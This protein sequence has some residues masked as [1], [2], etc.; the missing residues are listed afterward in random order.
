MRRLKGCEGRGQG[1]VGRVPT[2]ASASVPDAAALPPQLSP[3]P[4]GRRAKVRGQRHPGR[5]GSRAGLEPRE[6]GRSSAP[7]RPAPRHLFLLLTAEGLSG[8]L[9]HRAGGR[10]RRAAAAGPGAAA[11]HP[12]RGR[13]PAKGPDTGD[14]RTALP[15][16]SARRPPG[17]TRSAR[18]AHAQSGPLRDGAGPPSRGR[19][20][21]PPGSG[22]AG[23]AGSARRR[24]PA[25]PLTGF[26]SRRGRGRGLGAMEL[27]ELLYNKSEYIETVRVSPAF[28]ACVPRRAVLSPAPPRRVPGR[29]GRGRMVCLCYFFPCVAS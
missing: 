22:S 9:F 25:D 27:G 10:T 15:A 18:P 21:R 4:S 5:P 13:C 16:G 8:S 24:R 29:D 12:G 19:G 2:G 11:A 20:P 14:V 1:G 26:D 7:A 6:G 3:G 17:L 28:Q 23:A